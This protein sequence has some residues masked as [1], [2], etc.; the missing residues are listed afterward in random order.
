MTGV[1]QSIVFQIEESYGGGNPPRIKGGVAASYWVAA[2]PGSF[3]TSTHRRNTSRIQS[4]GS[5]FWDTVAYGTLQGTWE[6]TFYLDYNYP[7]PLFLIFEG[8]DE[9]NVVASNKLLFT[10]NN[11]KR[12][13]SFT[14][15][16]KLLNDFIG[17]ADNEVS[18]LK[19]CVVKSVTFSKPSSASYV[20]VSMSGFYSSEEL[21]VLPEEEMDET[22][23]T[24]YEGNLV[25]YGCLTSAEL[26][27]ADSDNSSL[28]QNTDQVSITIDN[29]AEQI[30]ST[31]SAFSTEYAEGLAR[32]TLSASSYSNHPTYYKAGVYSGGK[33]FNSILDVLFN[34]QPIAPGSK[35]MRPLDSAYL[36]SYNAMAR[37]TGGIIG[38]A[39]SQS[40]R[41]SVMHLDKVVINSLSWQKGDGGKLMDSVSGCPVRNLDIAMRTPA[42]LPYASGPGEWEDLFFSA[43]PRN[44][45]GQKTRV[46]NVI[47]EAV[48]RLEIDGIIYE[49]Q[50]TKGQAT[51]YSAVYGKS[52]DVALLS[53]ITS[54]SGV[55]YPVKTV[56]AKALQNMDG[57]QEGGEDEG[58]DPPVATR[59]IYITSLDIPES[60]EVID[61]AAFNN[62][63]TLTTVTGGEGLRTIGMLA[64][65]G[66]TSMT[67]FEPLSSQTAAPSLRTIG[68]GAFAYTA[69]SE[70][71]VPNT[72][73]T[74][75]NSNLRYINGAVR[76]GIFA[77][78]PNLAKVTMPM[79]FKLV[80]YSARQGSDGEW[81]GYPM[82]A[83]TE[84]VPD[85]PLLYTYYP[86]VFYGSTNITEFVFTQNKE[87]GIDGVDWTPTPSRDPA[88]DGQPASDIPLDD[89]YKQTPWYRS[90]V[91]HG[92]REV[93]ISWIY[94]T[95]GTEEGD[96]DLRDVPAY[97]FYIDKDDVRISAGSLPYKVYDMVP[98]SM[99]ELRSIGGNAFNNSGLDASGMS[100]TVSIDVEGAIEPYAFGD[101][102]NMT[103]MVLS[104]AGKMTLTGRMIS[105][106]IEHGEEF[107]G[108]STLETLDLSGCAEAA[109]ASRAIIRANSLTRVVTSPVMSRWPKDAILDTSSG[110]RPVAVMF[111]NGSYATYVSSSATA[112]MD[113]ASLA[114]ASGKTF[115]RDI[116]IT[117]PS[118]F[119]YVLKEQQLMGMSAVPGRSYLD[120]ASG[121]MVQIPGEPEEPVEEPADEPSS[122]EEGTLEL[123]P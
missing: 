46:N 20:Q 43:A 97:A 69:M 12:I 100:G 15:R 37:N 29:S 68:A 103:S 13:P 66:C 86:S 64:F 116:S 91:A 61:S 75:R 55:T 40:T 4:M 35:G 22:D 42:S 95:D 111:A 18:I 57:H 123:D 72:V 122:E 113:Q 107:P 88:Y 115:Q 80:A 3:F 33:D 53:E 110:Q 11:N 1:R 90:L 5:K 121:T 118:G 9:T 114:A 24:E 112:S 2:P 50:K 93:S 106:D 28:I 31:C 30:F 34:G 62:I 49:I 51:V 14:V 6:W 38:Q 8:G 32:I 84:E 27:D 48:E 99:E 17:G 60:I 7:E 44:A 73:T 23:Y 59:P 10:K 65:S 78:M 79:N 104:D 120:P 77:N 41:S 16:R 96:L 56:S 101:V 76:H 98:E 71:V 94:G 47:V 70:I 63:G 19:G 45:S 81:V 119:A 54:A 83:P 105:Y 58:G 102:L 108:D 36:T 109:F 67:E 25:E 21:Y 26:S 85:P 87:K 39:Y 117:P 89:T 52:G 74:M 92:D 82:D